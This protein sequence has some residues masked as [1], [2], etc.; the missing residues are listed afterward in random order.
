M[1][2]SE[3]KILQCEKTANAKVLRPAQ[4]ESSEGCQIMKALHAMVITL[5]FIT[6]EGFEQSSDMT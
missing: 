3:R 1:C 5:P 6:M 2:I 4:P